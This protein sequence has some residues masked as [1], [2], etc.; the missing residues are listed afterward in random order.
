LA[1]CIIIISDKDR[2]RSIDNLRMRLFRWMKHSSGDVEERKHSRVGDEMMGDLTD[3]PGARVEGQSAT[4]WGRFAPL[5][6]RSSVDSQTCFIQS[7]Q[8][9]YQASSLRLFLGHSSFGPSPSLIT[10]LSTCYRTQQADPSPHA[11]ESVPNIYCH[12]NESN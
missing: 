4:V 8:C 10:D 6:S 2:S 5:L 1:V 7:K 12:V 11:V 3:E 9:Q